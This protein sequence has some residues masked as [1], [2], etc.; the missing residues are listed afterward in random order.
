MFKELILFSANAI[1]IAVKSPQRGT[2]EDLQRKARPRIVCG[3][4]PKTI[5]LL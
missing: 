4:L 3:G 2:S 1:G 5:K